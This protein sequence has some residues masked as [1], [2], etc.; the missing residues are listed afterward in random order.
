MSEI[1]QLM[2]H[3]NWARIHEVKFVKPGQKNENAIRVYCTQ[4]PDVFAFQIRT[5]KPITENRK[6]KARNMIAH[7]EFSLTEMEEILAFMK[8]ITGKSPRVN[9][10]PLERIKVDE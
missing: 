1:K 9:T 6:G 3:K 8:A 10:D 7:V 5:H 4:H 2:A